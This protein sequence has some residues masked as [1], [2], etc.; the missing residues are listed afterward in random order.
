M[1]RSA[2]QSCAKAKKEDP[3]L[4]IMQNISLNNR[5]CCCV[6]SCKHYTVLHRK[7]Q[8][9]PPYK[10]RNCTGYTPLTSGEIEQ[11]TA[12]NHSYMD[13]PYAAMFAKATH[14]KSRTPNA[15]PELELGL[16]GKRNQ[17]RYPN[18]STCNAKHEIWTLSLSPNAAMFAKATHPTPQTPNTCPKFGFR[19]H[20]PHPTP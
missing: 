15:C 17:T 9:H 4:K 11:V 13:D 1:D 10:W 19:Q 2:L 6:G 3:G 20:T 12:M 18:H 7:P 8:E 16:R 5:I 14:P